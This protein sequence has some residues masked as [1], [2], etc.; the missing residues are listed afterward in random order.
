MAYKL[1]LYWVNI[2]QKKRTMCKK[3]DKPPYQKSRFFIASKGVVDLSLDIWPSRIA[4]TNLLQNIYLTL[5]LVYHKR[6]PLFITI[7]DA[8][9]FLKIF[10]TITWEKHVR[11]R[12]FVYLVITMM[13]L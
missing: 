1:H 2:V 11:K 10:K 12:Y 7:V 5:D 3:N 4:L 8:S 9:V 13:K 6:N